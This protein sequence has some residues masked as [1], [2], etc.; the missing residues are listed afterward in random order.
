MTQMYLDEAKEN[1]EKTEKALKEDLSRIRTGRANP[2][3]V[4]DLRV[5]YYGTPTPLFQLATVGTPDPKMILITPY[6]K[7]ALA[8]IEK[9]IQK[10]DLGIN[11][12][13]DGNGLRLTFPP[14]TED[15]RKDL[16]KGMKKKLEDAK[17]AMR[18]HRRAVNDQL[19]K[20]RADGEV[21]EDEE[22]KAQDK[23]QKLTDEYVKRV[24]QIGSEKEKD[25]MTT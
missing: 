21:T 5:N 10:S 9:A 2:T 12:L 20:G 23:V 1:M 4:K 24:D 8:E 6:D 7:T 14:L 15:R 11:P 17:V 25:I 22:K 18:N 3:L 16:V 19:K 13:V